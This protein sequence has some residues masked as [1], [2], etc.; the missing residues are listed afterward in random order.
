MESNRFG[1]GASGQLSAHIFFHLERY[2]ESDILVL[3]E[4]LISTRALAVE[5]P[6]STRGIGNGWKSVMPSSANMF[7]DNISQRGGGH[8]LVILPKLSAGVCDESIRMAPL[9]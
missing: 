5:D 3:P 2:T 6:F 8:A 9:E 1:S 4:G 7:I